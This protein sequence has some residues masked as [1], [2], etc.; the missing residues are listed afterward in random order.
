MEIDKSTRHQKIIGNF[1]ENLVCNF[2]S[3]SGFEVTLVDHTGIDVVAYSPRT[4]ERLGVSVKSRTR[5]RAQE[6]GSVNLFSYQR[7]K[8]DRERVM[9]A[10]RAFAAEPW[11]AVYVE[12]TTSA[13]L[14][15]T[16]LQN[17]DAKYRGRAGRAIDD[18]KMT[19]ANCD[20]YAEDAAVKH[21]HLELDFISWDWQA[22]TQPCRR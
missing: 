13:D 12:R 9:A 3:R 2:L 8:N 11:I 6:V 10:C 14:Y 7:G 20:K 16:S 1:G 17:Y 15:L 18:W 19:K 22:G 5:V 21:I 4:E